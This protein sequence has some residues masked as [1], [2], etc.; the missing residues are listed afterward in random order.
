MQNEIEDVDG[1]MQAAVE[2]HTQFFHHVEFG[3]EGSQAQQQGWA[4]LPFDGEP[5]DS[6]ASGCC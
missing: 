6:P 5:E 2:E 3:M 4:G 1:P